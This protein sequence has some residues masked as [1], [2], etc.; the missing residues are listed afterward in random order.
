M[1]SPL[2]HLIIDS[3]LKNK[4]GRVIIFTYW[5]LYYYYHRLLTVC[6]GES[7]Q[8]GRTIY[9]KDRFPGLFLK[10]NYMELGQSTI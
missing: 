5:F 7:Y 10:I 9:K 4:C 1:G 2:T 3:F 6:H 8:M